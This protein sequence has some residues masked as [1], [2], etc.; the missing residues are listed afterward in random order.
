MFTDLQLFKP[1]LEPQINLVCFVIVLP[2]MWKSLVGRQHHAFVAGGW[3]RHVVA[4][5][6]NPGDRCGVSAVRPLATTAARALLETENSNRTNQSLLEAPFATPSACYVHLPF[7]RR[8][9]HYCDFAVVAVGTKNRRSSGDGPDEPAV[10]PHVEAKYVDLLIAEIEATVKLYDAAADM[11]GAP[12]LAA[13]SSC[14]AATTLYIGGGTPS[15]VS[16][17]AI[18]RVIRAASSACNAH[19]AHHRP[20]PNADRAAAAGADTSAD[21]SVPVA[22]VGREVTQNDQHPKSGLGVESATTAATKTMAFDSATTNSSVHWDEVT[23]EIDPGSYTAAKLAGFV[24][25]GITRASVGIQSLEDSI[26][27]SAGQWCQHLKLGQHLSHPLLQI[28]GFVQKVDT[29]IIRMLRV[30]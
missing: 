23:L 15:L 10:A 22:R 29:R 2:H 19:V 28:I 9:C 1:V 25:L 20:Q 21:T 14:G 3:H 12:R 18:E 27:T 7:C 8:K 17:A 6:S 30:F 11:I 24:E 13:R 5:N 26:L 4:A 16:L